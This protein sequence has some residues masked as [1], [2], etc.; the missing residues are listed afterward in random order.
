MCLANEFSGE[1]FASSRRS[2]SELGRTRANS[3]VLRRTFDVL[4]KNSGGVRGGVDFGE[5]LANPHGVRAN[6]RGLARVCGELK[7][8]VINN[9]TRFVL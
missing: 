4:R 2:T 9:P 6:F 1:Q 3:G 5:P 7:F 8:A